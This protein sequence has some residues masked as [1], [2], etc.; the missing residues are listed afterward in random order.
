M[1]DSHYVAAHTV[2][3]YSPLIQTK[4]DILHEPT[5]ILPKFLT[6]FPLDTAFQKDDG[7]FRIDITT[8]PIAL[9]T[10]KPHQQVKRTATLH[11]LKE[12]MKW[13]GTSK[14][15]ITTEGNMETTGDET[16]MEEQVPGSE[17]M[18]YLLEEDMQMLS[19]TL[20]VYMHKGPALQWFRKGAHNKPFNLAEYA[21]FC[22]QDDHLQG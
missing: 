1:V 3:K 10:K 12:K 9:L 14:T 6:I 15:N 5:N 20:D 2:T 19:G 22:I 7:L 18:Q 8:T 21:S 4:H 13:R 17:I 16:V 11:C